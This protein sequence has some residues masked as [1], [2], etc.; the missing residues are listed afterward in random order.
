ME[1]LAGEYRQYE[2]RRS[3]NGKELWLNWLIA[4]SGNTVGIGYT[5]ATVYASHADVAWVVG[6]PWQG[7]G[8]ASEAAGALVQWLNN[9]G[10]RDIRA[11]VN[12]AHIASQRVAQK[13]GLEKTSQMVDGEEVWK[14][15]AG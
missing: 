9:L 14:C 12:P 2:S 13:A 11:C 10:V 6:V 1:W 8:F 3:P 5:Q 7:Q 4:Q 15:V